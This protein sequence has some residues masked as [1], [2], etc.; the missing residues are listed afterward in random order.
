PRRGA[1]VHAKLARHDL[2]QRGLAEARRAHEQHVV[3]RFAPRPCRRD[4]HAEVGARLLLPDEFVEP[5][6]AQRAFRGII[7]AALGGDEA[8]GRAA[9]LASSLRP[10]RISCDTSALSPTLRAAAAIA[11]AAWGSP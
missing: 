9:H 11:A 6:R 4:E 1:K 2:R 5:L 10:R 8:A 3:E 7:F